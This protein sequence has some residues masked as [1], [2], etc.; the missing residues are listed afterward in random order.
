MRRLARGFRSTIHPIATGYAGGGVFNGNAHREVMTVTFIITRMQIR[1]HQDMPGTGFEPAR[2]YA[3]QH[4]KLARLPISPPGQA[5]YHILINALKSQ[6]LR[7]RLMPG[8]AYKFT[9]IGRKQARF[10][11]RAVKTGFIRYIELLRCR[12]VP[13]PANPAGGGQ[14]SVY[15]IAG[16]ESSIV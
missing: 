13:L 3:H 16:R 1:T 15:V 4:L 6:A 10:K 11:V 5:G 9:I 8:Y 7:H 14:E 2:A 12:K